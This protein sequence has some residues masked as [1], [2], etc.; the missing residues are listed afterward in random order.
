[1]LS[2][3][4]RDPGSSSP[5]RTCDDVAGDQAGP[6]GGAARLHVRHVDSRR[7][8]GK[9]R[10]AGLQ[11]CRQAADTGGPQEVAQLL[12]WTGRRAETAQAPGVQTPAA[13][14][15]WDTAT[16]AAAAPTWS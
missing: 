7:D 12:C 3:T 11:L 5:Q 6:I 14:T 10:G 9:Q 13:V 8:V 16:E 15:T 4:A 2:S 1:M